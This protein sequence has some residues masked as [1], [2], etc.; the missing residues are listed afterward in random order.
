MYLLGQSNAS[1]EQAFIILHGMGV[2][3]KLEKESTLLR[4]MEL[5]ATLS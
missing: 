2:A 5:V 1:Q 4:H 3:G